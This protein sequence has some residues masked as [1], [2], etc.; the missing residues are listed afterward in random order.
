ML[1]L[2]LRGPSDVLV[3]T[4][5]GGYLQPFCSSAQDADTGDHHLYFY[6]KDQEGDNRD[7]IYKSAPDATETT[8]EFCLW[9]PNIIGSGDGLAAP[10]VEP[11]R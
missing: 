6:V 3:E 8:I 7:L 11:D 10:V 9:D 1:E 5:P 2:E 4:I